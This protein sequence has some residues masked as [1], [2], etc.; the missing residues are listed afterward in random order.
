MSFLYHYKFQISKL[1]SKSET[2]VT[3]DD[4][5]TQQSKHSRKQTLNGTFISYPSFV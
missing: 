4:V 2:N 1:R 5:G 3:S